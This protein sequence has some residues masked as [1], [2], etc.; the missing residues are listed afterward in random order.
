[1]KIPPVLQINEADDFN[2]IENS[3]KKIYNEHSLVEIEKKINYDFNDKAYLVVAF[4][5]SSYS[6]TS[7][8]IK[9]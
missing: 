5:H 2:R 7:I 1:M 4:T 3:I 8:T 6:E 9:R